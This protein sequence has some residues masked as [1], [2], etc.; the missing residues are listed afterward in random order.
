MIVG[1]SGI[2]TRDHVALTNLAWNLSGHT[3]AADVPVYLD[4]PAN[5]VYIKY[6]ST[7]VRIEFYVNNKL[8]NSFGE[9]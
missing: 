7:D 1:A 8:A 2:G 5:T 4:S 9:P 3:I 6:N